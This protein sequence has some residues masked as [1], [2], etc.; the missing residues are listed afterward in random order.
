LGSD[1]SRNMEMS[2]ATEAL[3]ALGQESRLRVFRLLIPHGTSGMSAGDI[4]QVLE[5]PPNTLSAHLAVLSR[6]GLVTSRKAGR[7]VIYAIDIEGTRSLLSFLVE[8]CC[9]AEKKVC[10]PLIASALSK[11]C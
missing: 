1:I 3:S 11:C 2:E 9:R 7:S 4:A 6:A 10:R 8:D 5:V